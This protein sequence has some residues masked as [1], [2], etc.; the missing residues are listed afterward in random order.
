MKVSCIYF[1]G[2][3]SSIVTAAFALFTVTTHLLLNGQL[4]L[5]ELVLVTV[6]QSKHALCSR[7]LPDTSQNGGRTWRRTCNFTMN[8]S[9]K[10]RTVQNGWT[11]GLQGITTQKASR[12]SWTI[13][14]HATT[15]GSDFY[16]YG[17]VQTFMIFRRFLFHFWRL[18]CNRTET[19]GK[20]S[21][22]P[23]H[24]VGHENLACCDLTRVWRV[25]ARVCQL[26]EVCQNEFANL[27]LPCEGRLRRTAFI[28]PLNLKSLNW[29]ACA[30]PLWD[31]SVLCNLLIG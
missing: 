6:N 17:F 27:S 31:G 21:W 8:S 12:T 15:E 10:F 28:C 29:W 20:S 18:T 9:T 23:L 24:Y 26:F 7:D 1:S 5:C 16:W 14:L 2:L 30:V 13:V 25:N 3:C 11:F 22:V 4:S 19:S